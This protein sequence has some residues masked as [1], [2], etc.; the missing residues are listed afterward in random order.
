VHLRVG[1]EDLVLQI[2]EGVLV[3]L[4]FALE[5]PIGHAASL[6]Q[7]LHRLVQDLIEPHGVAPLFRW[8]RCI[9]KGTK[10]GCDR[11]STT[12]QATGGGDIT[13]PRYELLWVDG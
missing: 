6:P 13:N 12:G 4:K 8:P 9:I 7:E 3:E 10:A 2:S 5:R 11:Q 1:I